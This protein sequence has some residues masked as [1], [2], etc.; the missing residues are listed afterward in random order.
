VAPARPHAAPRGSE[1]V[2]LRRQQRAPRGRGMAARG[3][4]R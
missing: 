1:C 2:R 3:E 4:R